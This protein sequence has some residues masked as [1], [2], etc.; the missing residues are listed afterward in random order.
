MKLLLAEDERSLPRALVTILEKSHYSV[1]PVFDG[2]EALEYLELG[3]SFRLAGKEFQMMELLMSNP[4]HLISTERFLERVWGYDSESE[5]NV[6]WVYISYLR[7]KL[8][9]IRANVRIKAVRNGGYYLE[10]IK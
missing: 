9:A 5:M 4:G 2:E 10:E 7:K 8:E 1:D 3:G 6:V